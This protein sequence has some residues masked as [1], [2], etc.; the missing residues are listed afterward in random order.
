TLF[1]RV[2]HEIDERV[3]RPY[4]EG[5]KVNWEP[6]STNWAGVCAGC[7]LAACESFAAMGMPRNAAKARALDTLA[8]YIR[9]GFTEHGECDEGIG[10]WNYGLANAVRGWMRLSPEEYA[11]V[12]DHERL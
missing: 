12:V 9:D 1:S 5:D 2:I 11:A 10:Y 4:G 8:G 3:L 6:A 7:I